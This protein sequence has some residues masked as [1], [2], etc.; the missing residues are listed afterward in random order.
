M[1]VAGFVTAEI[2]AFY[3]FRV[4]WCTKQIFNEQLS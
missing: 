4:D 1:I 3:S 2:L